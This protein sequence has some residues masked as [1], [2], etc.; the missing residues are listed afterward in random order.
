MAR[1]SSS[2]PWEI[3]DETFRARENDSGRSRQRPDNWSARELLAWSISRGVQEE[4]GIPPPALVISADLESE[5][6]GTRREMV[7]ATYDKPLSSFRRALFPF[8]RRFPPPWRYI[9]GVLRFQTC[10]R[11]L[12]RA[13]R[14]PRR[15][16]VVWLGAG[17]DN[18]RPAARRRSAAREVSSHVKPGSRRPK[19]P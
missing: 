13:A 1:L 12:T 11:R 2:S 7:G 19:W 17:W 4:E 5:A 8:S 16:L 18:Y 15:T 3:E 14:G 6:K 9:R 10:T